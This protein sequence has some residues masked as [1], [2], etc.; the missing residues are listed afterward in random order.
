M[1]LQDFMRNL[2]GQND[3]EDFPPAYL[4]QI[5][6]AVSMNEILMPDEHEGDLAAPVTWMHVLR[7][8][9]TAQEYVSLGANGINTCLDRD[10]F[11]L[12]GPMIV[13]AMVRVYDCFAANEPDEHNAALPGLSHCANIATAFDAPD[14]VDQLVMDLAEAGRL[15]TVVSPASA[16][17]WLSNLQLSKTTARMF[18]FA[19]QHANLLRVAWSDIFDIVVRLYS[20]RV[21]PEL[22]AQVEDFL[23]P[24]RGSLYRFHSNQ[25][26]RLAN[27]DLAWGSLLGTPGSAITAARKDQSLLATLSSLL[28]A[29]NDG[30]AEASEPTGPL[31]PEI[32]HHFIEFA[33]SLPLEDLLGEIRSLNPEPLEALLGSLLSLLRERLRQPSHWMSDDEEVA[34]FILELF[35]NAT[36]QNKD[37]ILSIWPLVK[38]AIGL[39][40]STV[41][42][43]GGLS[44]EATKTDASLETQGARVSLFLTERALVGLLRLCMR[45]KHRDDVLPVLLEDLGHVLLLP[46]AVRSAIAPQLSA[47][48]LALLRTD[49]APMMRSAI[50]RRVILAIIRFCCIVPSACANSLDALACIILEKGAVCVT[51]DSLLD[52]L[53]TIHDVAARQQTLLLELRPETP[54]S[55]PGHQTNSASERDRPKRAAVEFAGEAFNTLVHMLFDLHLRTLELCGIIPNSR[56]SLEVVSQTVVLDESAVKL[57]RRLWPPV[58]STLGVLV[59][60]PL[61]DV[62]QTVLTSM[63][64]A[65]CCPD[66]NQLPDSEMVVIFEV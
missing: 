33:K 50:G 59:T 12:V 30:S 18:A 22:M 43:S 14:I 55:P 28:L 42:A 49:A 60:A 21:L 23:A 37:R 13:N 35:L 2:R 57:W 11:A 9:S 3:G 1:T 10:V 31:N 24:G 63:Q 38:E 17:V 32:R 27:S 66:L 4:E 48:V 36:I 45:L 25:R 39:A 44:K 41:P 6:Q 46:S 51:A 53:Q 65:L 19:R 62:R 61:K 8:Q 52:L 40:M 64:R 29:A 5:F 34:A 54:V 56:G 20:L 7:R 26:S 58:L 16:V 15:G 47:G